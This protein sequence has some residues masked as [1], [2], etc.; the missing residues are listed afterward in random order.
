MSITQTNY[1]EG[2]LKKFEL[3]NCKSVSTPLETGK[4]YEKLSDENES[5]DRRT[6]QKAIGCLTYAATIS[7]QICPQP[8]TYYLS[9]GLI[10]VYSIG[11]D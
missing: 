6:Y 3:E 5:F 7:R 8:S 11:K 2:V 10:L 1:L 4:K 9:L